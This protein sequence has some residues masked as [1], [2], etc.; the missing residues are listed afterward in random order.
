MATWHQE[1]NAAGLSALWEPHPSAWKC[2]DDKPGR[3]AGSISFEC[4]S[5]AKAYAE[6]TGAHLIPP[7]GKS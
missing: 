5:K 4:E 2:I 1:R 3:P 6:K 7:K